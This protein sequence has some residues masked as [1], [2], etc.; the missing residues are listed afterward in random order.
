[1]EELTRKENRAKWLLFAGA[2]AAFGV[3]A[4][5]MIIFSPPERFKYYSAFWWYFPP[6][7][8]LA[9]ILSWLVVPR[10]AKGK[11]RPIIH[12]LIFALLTGPTLFGPEGTWIP[13]VVFIAFIAEICAH[14]SLKEIIINGE[15][16]FILLELIG[17]LLLFTGILCTGLF[18]QRCHITPANRV[19]EVV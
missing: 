10:I 15:F 8:L 7:L 12:G 2:V 13:L 11:W 6:G 1:M 9:I 14:T 5:G 4:A 3:L 18:L 16:I 17:P 19:E